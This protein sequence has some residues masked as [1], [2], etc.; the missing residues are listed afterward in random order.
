MQLPEPGHITRADVEAAVSELEALGM[1]VSIRKIRKKLGS[2]SLTTILKYMHEKPPEG[3]EG[4]SA[5]DIF[6]DLEKP[7][8]KASAYEKKFSKTSMAGKPHYLISLLQAK[9]RARWAGLI[10]EKMRALRALEIE[11]RNSFLLQKELGEMQCKCREIEIAVTKLRLRIVEIE[12]INYQL[13]ERLKDAQKHEIFLKK[14]ND[15][16]AMLMRHE[17]AGTDWYKQQFLRAK[18]DLN[19]AQTKVDSLSQELSLLRRN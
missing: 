7:I 14:Y 10:R 2:G 4:S 6:P 11:E 15:E 16:L 8:L 3:I 19:D 13:A 5:K 17:C 9:I 12:T 18:Q 1:R